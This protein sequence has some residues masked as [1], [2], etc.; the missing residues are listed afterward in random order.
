MYLKE[1]FRR[2]RPGRFIDIGAGDGRLSR[3]LL[4]S[5][6]TGT[7]FEPGAGAA[8]AR[9]L[10]ADAA[11]GGR[12]VLFADNWLEAAPQPRADLIVSSMV[13]EHLDDADERRYFLR[14]ERELAVGGLA[15]LIVP[16]SP[17]HWG[18]E[19]EI[20]GHHRR[21]TFVKLDQTLREV[22]WVATHIVGLTFPVSNVLW[23]ISEYLVAK[24]EGAKKTLSRAKR[25]ALSGDRDVFLKTRF[26]A[27]LSVVLNE[28]VMYPFHVWQ[29]ANA[30][31]DRSLVI[32]VE[33]RPDRGRAFS[34]AESQP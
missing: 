5:G 1:R 29:K 33:C 21:Y 31:N 34:K 16:G 3:L 15:I 4:D 13:L 19:D 6:W 26:P 24:A 32:Y 27:F 17:A 14:A 22:G 30:A 2:L 9:A 7:G 28:R 18:I 8:K 25:T 12:Y 11:A 10:T 23:A 20:A